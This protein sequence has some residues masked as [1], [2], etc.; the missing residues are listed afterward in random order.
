MEYKILD[1]IVN[2]DTLLGTMDL[3]PDLACACYS[4]K[5]CKVALARGVSEEQLAQL[6]REMNPTGDYSVGIIKVKI[7]GGDKSEI[8]KGATKNLLS[9]LGKI[10]DNKNVIDII[11]FDTNERTHPE[12]FELNCYH[13][14]V[15][16]I[17]S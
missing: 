13:G 16:P 2:Q 7:I 9:W 15:H 14:G 6:F 4:Q 12:S 3:G 11:S 17:F 8:S 10:D 1:T 5:L